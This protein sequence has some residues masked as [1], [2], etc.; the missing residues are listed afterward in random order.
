MT[1]RDRATVDVHLVEVDAGFL[2][3]GEYDRGKGFI[4][5]EQVDVVDL[6]NK[7]P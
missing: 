4:A 3:P 7:N 6:K 5:F 1:E 2:L